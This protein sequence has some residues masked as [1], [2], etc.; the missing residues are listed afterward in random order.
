[1][2]FRIYLK[3]SKMLVFI[4]SV[5]LCACGRDSRPPDLMAGRLQLVNWGDHPTLYSPAYRE[6]LDRDSIR[7]LHHGDMAIR[8][9]N[10]IRVEFSAIKNGEVL[11]AKDAP[12]SRVRVHPV[13]VLC[14]H[15]DVG[16]AMHSLNGGG[17]MEHGT[18][19]IHKPV[20]AFD[21]PDSAEAFSTTWVGTKNRRPSPLA[22]ITFTLCEE[23]G[24]STPSELRKKHAL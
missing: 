6:Y 12:V 7:T 16:Y 10:T 20:P 15:P 3:Q 21:M 13:A 23:S 14:D 8:T 1:M 5:L 2:K 19:S 24:I 4:F 22:R 11:R 18:F 17:V 9:A